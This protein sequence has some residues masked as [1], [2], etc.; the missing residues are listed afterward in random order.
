[1]VVVRCV[2][3]PTTRCSMSGYLKYCDYETNSALQKYWWLILA[4]CRGFTS[5]LQLPL[6]GWAGAA[7][8]RGLLPAPPECSPWACS[9]QQPSRRRASARADFSSWISSSWSCSFCSRWESRSSMSM[10]LL[11]DTVSSAVHTVLQ[12]KNKNHC[13]TWLI[14]F[15]T[16]NSLLHF[17]AR[18]NKLRWV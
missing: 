17:N 12:K 2:N 5:A 6:V 14:C 18:G 1:M 9:S 3:R 4:A 8:A 13:V 10:L 16:T 11:A 15:H 7:A